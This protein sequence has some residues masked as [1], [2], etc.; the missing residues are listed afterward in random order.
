MSEFIFRRHELKYLVS[1]EQRSA[2][3]KAFADTMCPDPY[4]E[5]TICSVYYD[6][7]DFRLIR[8]S[9]EKPVYKEKLR[10]RSYGPAA[11]ETT[12]FLEL[13]KKYETVVYKRRVTLTA[14][15]AEACMTE[16]TPVPGDSQIG[17]E[18]DYFRRFYRTLRPA[19]YLSC[20][21]SAWFSQ[22]SRDLRVTF[23]RHIAWRREAMRLTAPAG[24]EELLP[25]GM[26]LMEVKAADAIP[27]WLASLMSRNGVR[28]TTYSKY[29]E[30]Y[31]TALV[32]MGLAQGGN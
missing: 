21:R 17:R 8:A 15:D 24:G 26:S 9:L 30:A 31:R 2:L 25:E 19:M 22:E 29:G 18:I 7:P 3:E 14:E 23:D 5:S 13:K 20:D 16:G 32:P 12:V 27:V 6:T 28:Q 1:D 4:G 11:P 10:L